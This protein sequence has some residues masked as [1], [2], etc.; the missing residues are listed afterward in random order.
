MKQLYLVRH[1]KSSWDYNVADRNRPLQER[2]INDALLVAKHL[3][4]NF[5]QP[6][7]VFSSPANRALH[8]C[9][10]FMNSLGIPLS[11]LQVNE[12]LYDFEGRAVGDFIKALDN[13]FSNVMIFGHN[14]AFTAISNIFGSETID[15]LPTAGVVK[16]NFEVQNWEDITSGNT[17][18]IIFPKQLK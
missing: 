3:K 2:G 6:D 9:T 11:K 1:G 17:E 18:L 8:T 15:N 13:A 10:I 14:H 7:I 16:I 5:I 12:Q 4:S